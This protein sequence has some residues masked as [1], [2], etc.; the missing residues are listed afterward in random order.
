M[1]VTQPWNFGWTAFYFNG[2]T[3]CLCFLIGTLGNFV[4]FLYFKSK[5]REISNVLYILITANDVVVSITVLPVGIS[6]LSKGEPGIIFKNKYGCL[7][8]ENTWRIATLSSV[9]LVACLCI[10]R[11]IS[12]LRPFQRQKI[13]YLVI[14][15]VF[16]LLICAA[17]SA[18]LYSLH[19][20]HAGFN[21]RQSRCRY[22]ISPF[23]DRVAEINA[24]V[25]TF[26]LF[27]TAPALVVVISCVISVVVL[28]RRNRNV[29]QRILQ[30]SRNRATV[31]ILMFALLY[32]VCNIPLII[33]QVVFTV[34]VFAK[35]YQIYFDFYNFDKQIYYQNAAQTLLLSANSAAN[36]ILYFWRM[37]ALREYIMSG[38]RR[39]LGLNRK[40]RRRAVRKVPQAR[41]CNTVVENI[42][43]IEGL[44]A[45]SNQESGL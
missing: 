30:K 25:L 37:P 32:A 7:V 43:F 40:V 10:T 34:S 42:N 14:A 41:R 28:T 2:S 1:T 9:F 24:V 4:S 27:Y 5:S 8:W 3:C 29:Q 17:K 15:L 13:R 16:Y 11:T 21:A 12:L 33:H 20:V 18:V 44:P 36:P 45:S 31:T 39:M 19:F 6:F 35:S 38:I 23:L 22:L 26:N